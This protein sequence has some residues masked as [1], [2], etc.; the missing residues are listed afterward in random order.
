M[1]SLLIDL[2]YFPITAYYLTLN[3]HMHVVFDIYDSHRK[4]SFRNRSTIIGANGVI[5][6]SIPLVGGRDQRT[7]FR[8]VQID[9]TSGWQTAH[10]RSIV[11]AYRRAPF[12]EFYEDGLAAL[13]R[14]KDKFLVDWNL[15]CLDWLRSS[16]RGNWRYSLTETM[17]IVDANEDVT[18]LRNWFFPR[19]ISERSKNMLPYRQ[20][21]EER[22][23]FIPNVSVLD[24]LFCA[25]PGAVVPATSTL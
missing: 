1:N 23:G 16:M 20:V 22:L 18:D 25:G 7:I 21:F 8:D 4:M 14:R 2:Q 10:H 24:F 9:N 19:W 17:R 6:L 12:F 13:F 11:S 3:K 5:N 15:A